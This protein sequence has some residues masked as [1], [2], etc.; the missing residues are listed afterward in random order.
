MGPVYY[1]SLDR[2]SKELGP[3]ANPGCNSQGLPLSHP[4]PP[5]RMKVPKGPTIS[6]NLLEISV[7]TPEPMGDISHSN[8]GQQQETADSPGPTVSSSPKKE[9]FS[10]GSLRHPCF[11]CTI[12][13]DTEGCSVGVTGLTGM[14][15][16]GV[17]LPEEGGTAEALSLTCCVLSPHMLVN[18]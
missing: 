13:G 9:A 18:H 4:L 2:E 8:H 5:A 1:I 17:L 12:V 6:P 10:A 16:E 7:Q 14:N 15:F 3:E 11:T